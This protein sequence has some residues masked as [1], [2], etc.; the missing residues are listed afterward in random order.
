[1]K[2]GTSTTREERLAWDPQQALAV[3]RGPGPDE[4]STV[5]IAMYD[6]LAAADIPIDALDM[7]IMFWSRA[8]DGLQPGPVPAD[9]L[10]RLDQ[11][12]AMEMRTSPVLAR[13]LTALR[14]F[15]VTAHDLDW[16]IR[17]CLQARQTWLLSRQLRRQ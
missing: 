2:I 4:S 5:A 17:F 15:A 16:I 14:A 6:Q 9:R 7:C 3:A 13:W 1:M 11:D 10:Q 12:L 8:L